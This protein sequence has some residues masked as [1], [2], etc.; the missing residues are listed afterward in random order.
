MKD[1]NDTEQLHTF[2]LSP[3]TFSGGWDEEIGCSVVTATWSAWVEI[4][5]GGG[6]M[7]EMSSVAEGWEA[8]T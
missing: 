4:F 5:S 8:E 1:K 2:S 3:K 7:E 6:G